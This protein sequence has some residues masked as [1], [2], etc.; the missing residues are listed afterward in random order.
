ME[1]DRVLDLQLWWH[2]FIGRQISEHDKQAAGAFLIDYPR[3][4]LDGIKA[5]IIQHALWR[6]E[7][8]K[9]ALGKLEFYRDTLKEQETFLADQGVTR[10]RVAI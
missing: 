8:N 2:E 6:V 5:R 7:H 3:L 9:P 4:G 10:P 1:N